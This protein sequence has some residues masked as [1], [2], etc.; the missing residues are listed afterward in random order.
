MLGL[1]RP[2]STLRS[3]P[4]SCGTTRPAPARRHL[5]RVGG[6]ALA[7]AVLV[8]GTLATAG[9]AAATG[10]LETGTSETG[11]SE[12]GTPGPATTEAVPSAPGD[13][14]TAPHHW[15][16][17]DPDDWDDWD[18][19]DGD[20]NGNDDGGNDGGNGGGNDGGGNG[21]GGAGTPLP[22]TPRLALTR[23]VSANVAFDLSAARQREDVRTAVRGADVVGWQEISTRAQVGAINGQRGW[24]TYWPGGRRRDGRIALSPMNSNPI[25][26]RRDTWTLVSANRRLASLAIPGVCRDRHLSWVVLQHRRSGVRVLRW[27]IHFVPAAWVDRRVSFKALRQAAWNRQARV[28]AALVAAG[29]RDGHAA[30]I[31]GGDVN[32]RAA[33]LGDRVVYDSG[34]D[35]IDYLVHAPSPRVAALPAAR[36]PMNSDH[37]KLTVTYSIHR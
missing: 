28:L 34:H 17:P 33:F 4:D 30:V 32:R 35:H 8:T 31:G 1:R 11:T 25:S 7:C 36:A 13:P 18:G 23:Q 15:H 21:G 2:T 16:W 27:N 29:T 14:A 3:T 10:T 26:W 12:T 19:W 37:D 24:S 22:T 5:A 6:T 20:G 9:S